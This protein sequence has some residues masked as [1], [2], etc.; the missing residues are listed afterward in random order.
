MR[1]VF[2][3]VALLIALVA[4]YA[5]ASDAPQ[6]TR[7]L[8]P[9]KVIPRQISGYQIHRYSIR[10]VAKQFVH[11]VVEQKGADVVVVLRGPD[12][13]KILEQ[14]SPNGPVGPEIVKFISDVAGIYTIEVKLFDSG[15]PPGAY[16]A[17]L[18][19]IRPATAQ[20]AQFLADHPSG[21]TPLLRLK[22]SIEEI[23]HSLNAKWGVYIKCTETGEE[24]A[25]N[26]D[27]VM[28]TMSVIKLA[29][30]AEVFRQAEAGK[31][32]LTDRITL[33]EADKRPGTGVLRLLDPGASLTIKDLL[34]LMIAVSDNSA[35]DILYRQVGGVKP[36]NALM[37]RYGLTTIQAS[38]T[39]EEWF[40]ALNQE[41]DIWKFHIEGKHPFGLA[42]PRD[43]GRLLEK[44]AKSELVSQAASRQM[45]DMMRNQ[46]YA[47]RLPRYVYWFMIA[48]KTGDFMPYIGNDVGI[49]EMPT[50][51]VI[52]CVFTAHHNGAGAILEEAIGRIAEKV[53]GYFSYE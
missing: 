8:E 44:I 28:D 26:A 45:L 53:T 14:D 19:A 4:P 42:S 11:V 50:R 9:G 46:V 37:Q 33:K 36:V 13:R 18:E 20:D 2:P 49:I 22:Q 48:H 43:M 10:T 52:I 30:M 25:L 16:E 35:T 31:F 27:E 6:D 21:I 51:H 23:T 1:F 39:A 38:G 34:S 15:A 29:L 17:R 12:G 7:F 32:A 5:R 47:T 41:P 24:V 3:V 40:K